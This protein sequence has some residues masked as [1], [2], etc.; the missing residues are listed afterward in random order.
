MNKENPEKKKAMDRRF[1][2]ENPEK[3]RAYIRKANRK[4][5]AKNRKKEI[6]VL[7][8]NPLSLDRGFFVTNICNN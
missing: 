1:K 3:V 8:K 7:T 4:Y 6:I 2:K 5:Y